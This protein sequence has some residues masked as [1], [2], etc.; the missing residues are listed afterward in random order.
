[1]RS[2]KLERRNI[3]TLKDPH[4]SKE[5]FRAACKRVWRAQSAWD[6]RDHKITMRLKAILSPIKARHILI[7]S[8]MPKEAD[9]RAL[10]QWLRPIAKLFVPITQAQG[11]KIA[12]YRLPLQKNA[13]QILEPRL[14]SLA[15]PTLDVV[16]VP[17]LGL[18]GACRRIGF[19]KGF[20]DR[21]FATLKTRPYTI[22][23][24]RQLL[25]TPQLLGQDHD[26]SASLCVDQNHLY[27]LQNKIKRKS[28]DKYRF[29][30]AVLM[31]S[32]GR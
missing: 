5:S 28:N 22:F 18:E 19:G 23:I 15:T 20:Y 21:F 32:Y 1:M 10:I 7:Y 17:I 24:S 27:Q 30:H 16:L 31:R 2:S 12:P 14:S 6:I 8:P 3:Q 26:I 4:F 25:Y 29:K 11:L 13:Y 9:I